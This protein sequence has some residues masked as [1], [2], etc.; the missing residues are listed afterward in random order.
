[1]TSSITVDF[2]SKG[3]KHHGVIY[4]QDGIAILKIDDWKVTK[5]MY[6]AESKDPNAKITWDA[7]R[8]VMIEFFPSQ[9][10]AQIVAELKLRVGK[11]QKI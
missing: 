1:M 2:A 9:T 10:E 6:D 4:V 5:A 11:L 8:K 7:K 3:M